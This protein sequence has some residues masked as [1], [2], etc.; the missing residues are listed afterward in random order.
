[1]NGE[2]RVAREAQNRI[3][4]KVG[5]RCCAAMIE[6]RVA[7]RFYQ[8][9]DEVSPARFVCALQ[10]LR[11]ELVEETMKCGSKNDSDACKKRQAAE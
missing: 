10:F 6:G 8:I 3:V 11:V 4:A 2:Y 9:S 1:M 7:A 5:R